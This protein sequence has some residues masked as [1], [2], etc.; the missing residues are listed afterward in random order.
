M[1]LGAKK[2]LEKQRALAATRL[3]KVTRARTARRELA[4]RRREHNAFLV[5]REKCA[6]YVQRVYRGHR[7]RDRY[8]EMV[9]SIAK[10][11]EAASYLQASLS[12]CLSVSLSVCVCV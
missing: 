1:R 5:K 9:R 11:H 7:A 12:L 10:Q 4:R 6:R 2:L 3:Q 8:L